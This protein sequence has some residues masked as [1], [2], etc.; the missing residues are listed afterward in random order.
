MDLAALKQRTAH[1]WGLG[2]YSYL[3]GVLEPAARALCEACAVSPR[4][5][6]LDVAAGDGNFALAAAE[7]GARVVASDISP[8]M[9]ERG[10][11]RSQRERYDVEWLEADAEALPF[12]DACF[13]CVGSVFGAMIA[14]R[15]E[16]VAR[17]LFRVARPGGV[18]GM[19]AW[20]PGSF[21]AELIAIG[22][23]YVPPPEDLPH[24]HEWGDET[25]V[26]E[27]FGPH[28]GSIAAERRTLLW[29]AASADELWRLL[30]E[31]VPSQQAQR[32]AL[33]ADDYEA[34]RREH[35]DLTERFDRRASGSLAVEA[36]YLLVV[37]RKRG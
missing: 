26:R 36:E 8:G 1:M 15:P 22:R 33:S 9:V 13:D 28:A 21:A 30:D 2:D 6:V 23:R 4:D 17:E 16:L 37:A 3:S 5:E 34:M 14:P 35:V 27:R 11:A 19:T 29:E 7:R 31:T 32:E 10:R 25:T 18:V 12:N 20:T 24:A